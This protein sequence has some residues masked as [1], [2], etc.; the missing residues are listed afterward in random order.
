M[1]GES[2]SIV[3]HQILDQLREQ[4]SLHTHPSR[5]GFTYR[6]KLPMVAGPFTHGL[7]LGVAP[8]QRVRLLF[9]LL[10]KEF[11][12]DVDIKDIDTRRVPA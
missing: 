10:G 11:P 5:W 6:Q 9:E 8:G 1:A 2:P 12:K 3:R 7:Y 4:E